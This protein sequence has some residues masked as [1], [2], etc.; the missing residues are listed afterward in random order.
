MSSLFNINLRRV[1]WGDVILPDD[2]NSKVDALI[3]LINISKDTAIYIITTYG[4]D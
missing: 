4:Y 2:H 3:E 1:N